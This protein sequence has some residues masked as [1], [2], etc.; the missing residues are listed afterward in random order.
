[1]ASGS[2]P[3]IEPGLEIHPHT[4]VVVRLGSEAGFDI[5][6]AGGERFRL[7][8]GGGGSIHGLFKPGGSIQLCAWLK[9]FRCDAMRCGAGGPVQMIVASGLCH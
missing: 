3:I 4:E 8:T 2:S 9:G 1:M 7:V 5:I 6:G